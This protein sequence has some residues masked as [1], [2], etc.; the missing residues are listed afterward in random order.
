MGI[1]IPHN[2]DEQHVAAMRQSATTNS[3]LGATLGG[4]LVVAGRT[5]SGRHSLAATLGRLPMVAPQLTPRFSDPGASHEAT[6]A[7]GGGDA[8]R[9]AVAS[10]A[11]LDT[12]GGRKS[13]SGPPGSRFL[14]AEFVGGEVDERCVYLP[15]R[16]HG[17]GG[18]MHGGYGCRFCLKFLGFT[19]AYLRTRTEV[20]VASPKKPRFSIPPS[21]TAATRTLWPTALMNCWPEAPPRT[22]TRA[23]CAGQGRTVWVGPS[24]KPVPAPALSPWMRRL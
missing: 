6:G 16:A 20:V 23:V 18:R 9:D 3:L 15:R 21:P 5:V 1:T 14:T 7:A 17:G 10:R 12:T 2:P 13:K 4:P 19:H 11:S 8:R 22:W 24:G